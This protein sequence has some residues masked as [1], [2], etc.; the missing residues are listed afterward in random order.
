[1][2]YSAK[3]KTLRNKGELKVRGGTVRQATLGQIRGSQPGNLRCFW[4][5]LEKSMRESERE[6]HSCASGVRMRVA[7]TDEGRRGDFREDAIVT[8][9]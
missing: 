9:H 1:M 2:K 6:S 8:G 3:N 5:N 7:Q 4:E